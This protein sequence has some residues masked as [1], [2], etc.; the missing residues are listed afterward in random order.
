MYLLFI[1]LGTI[2]NNKQDLE[3]F[4]IKLIKFIIIAYHLSKQN[5]NIE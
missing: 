3:I 4:I 2:E 1:K 5:I